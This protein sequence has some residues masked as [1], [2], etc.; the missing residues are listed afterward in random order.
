MFAEEERIIER[1]MICNIFRQQFNEAFEH[2]PRPTSSP[3]R[4]WLLWH[5]PQEVC[6]THWLTG[7]WKS[8]NSWPARPQSWS[9]PAW[10]WSDWWAPES[11]KVSLQSGPALLQCPRILC[12]LG[13]P[14]AW[15]Q[16]P[17]LWSPSHHSLWIGLSAARSAT[18]SPHED[19][20][21]EWW[22]RKQASQVSGTRCQPT[23]FLLMTLK[24]SQQKLE[25]VVG[26]ARQAQVPHLGFSLEVAWAAQQPSC[27][28][29]SSSQSQ[30]LSHQ[31][32][33]H[34][35]LRPLLLIGCPRCL[36]S[37][38]LWHP[39]ATHQTEPWWSTVSPRIFGKLP[40]YII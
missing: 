26:P 35:I 3:N 13:S 14:E 24:L 9:C 17:W 6:C 11:W 36:T 28:C 12:S 7:P 22:P 38:L 39:P 30:S 33:L 27:F 1:G 19:H 16:C 20:S 21:E 4:S 25:Q 40:P 34:Q 31:T 8:W 37:M 23:C 5:P 10:A 18:G 29:L 2:P 15:S 32:S